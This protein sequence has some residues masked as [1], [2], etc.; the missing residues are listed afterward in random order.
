[1]RNL[2]LSSRG[3]PA[4]KNYRPYLGQEDDWFSWISTSPGRIDPTSG[5]F[6]ESTA[7]PEK[8]R[9]GMF[10]WIEASPGRVDPRTGKL[11]IPTTLPKEQREKLR[12]AAGGGE[13]R[14][15][16]RGLSRFG[17]GQRRELPALRERYADAG[18]MNGRLGIG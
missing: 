1:M 17:G 12:R 18:S 8:E 14:L 13:G 11:V 5:E 15:P 4:V 10:D 6:V 9:T 16:E 3:Q 2:G 7:V